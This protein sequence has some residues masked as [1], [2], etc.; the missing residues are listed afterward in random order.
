MTLPGIE[1]ETLCLP[2]IHRDRLVI[3][4]V[5]Y[6]RLKLFQYS[7]VQ[8]NARGNSGKINTRQYNVSN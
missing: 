5:I 3:E 7:R 1:L 2:A 8:G 4:M 6:L